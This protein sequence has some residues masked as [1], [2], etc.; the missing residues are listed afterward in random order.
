M[1]R[2]MPWRLL[3]RLSEDGVSMNTF[4][5]RLCN[6]ETTLVIIK[7]SNSHIFGG[8]C[9]EEWLF[10]SSFYGTGDNFVFTFRKGDRCEMWPASGDNF[11]YQYCDQSGFGMG[12]GMNEGRFA[13]FLGRDL[14]NGNSYKTECFENECLS[15]NE[16]F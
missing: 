13:M 16:R 9:T 2:L 15:S 3:Y 6:Q 4:A 1:Y 10:S 5:A 11:M 14:L 12:G 7:D 8:F